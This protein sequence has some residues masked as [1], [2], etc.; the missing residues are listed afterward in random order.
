MLQ[1]LE[2]ILKDENEN[3]K[4]KI[5]NHLEQTLKSNAITKRQIEHAKSI[6]KEVLHNDFN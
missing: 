3:S 2:N 1:R 5:T 6:K 4:N